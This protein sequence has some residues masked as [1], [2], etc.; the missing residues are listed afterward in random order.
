MQ[1]SAKLKVSLTFY[2]FLASGDSYHNLAKR[3]RTAPPTVSLIVTRVCKAIWDSLVGIHMPEPTTEEWKKI[4]TEFRIRWNFPNCVGAIDGKHCAVRKPPGSGSN[5]FNYK[6][7]FS[8]VLMAVVDAGYRFISVD[9]G[10][11]GSNADHGIFK[12]SEFGKKFYNNE[13]RLP[14]RKILPGFPEAGLIPHCFV[15]DEAFPCQ[16]DLMRP[17]PRGARGTK[18]PEDQLVFNYRVSRA[19]R[20]VEC[21]FGI[22]VQRFRVFDRKMYLSDEN[23]IKVTQACTVLH[24]YLTPERTDYEAI[25]RRLNPDGQEYNPNNGALRNLRNN[26]GY[27]TPNDA[28]EIRNWYKAYFWSPVGS[29][30]WQWESISAT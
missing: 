23:A 15:A 16:I 7:H 18:L 4:E 25:M 11:Y 20:I 13:L 5:Y 10:N 12:N 17:Y 22:L 19:R 3:F 1:Y 29:V 6:G 24:N 14:G 30:P 26:R 9:I 8:I 27:H 28:T 2:R 21:A